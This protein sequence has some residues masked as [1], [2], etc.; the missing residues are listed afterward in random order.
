[1][2]LSQLQYHSFCQASG[3]VAANENIKGRLY[4]MEELSGNYLVTLYSVSANTIVTVHIP[5]CFSTGKALK[6]CVFLVGIC[7][8]IVLPYTSEPIEL[9]EACC[10]FLQ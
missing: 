3:H 6:K 10:S 2:S 4:T 1:M 8:Q 7:L 5:S 9:S